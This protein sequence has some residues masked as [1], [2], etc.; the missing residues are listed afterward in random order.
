[1]LVEHGGEFLLALDDRFGEVDEI[2]KIQSEGK[3]EIVVFY[4]RD[5]PEPGT[6]TAITCGLSSAEHPDWK[7]GAPELIVSLDTEDLGWGLAAAYFA[8]ALGF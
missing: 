1:M 7:H 8:S 3:P 2:R 6:L 5:L 4:F